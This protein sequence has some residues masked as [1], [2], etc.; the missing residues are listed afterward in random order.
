DVIRFWLDKGVDGF[1]VD[2]IQNLV[3]DASF[4]DEPAAAN[5]GITDPTLEGYYNHIYTLNQPETMDIIRGWHEILE[6]YKDRFMTLEVY[7]ANMKV[8][9]NFMVMIR[10][11]CLIFLSISCS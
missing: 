8:L 11:Q 4:A 9:M 5:S 2:A 10:I 3:E 6:T 1:R 7:D